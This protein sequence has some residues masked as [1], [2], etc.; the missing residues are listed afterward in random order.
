MIIIHRV[1]KKRLYFSPYN[2][3]KRKL[4]FTVFGTHYADD[5]LYQ[6]HLKLIFKICLS[7]N[8]ANVI[9]TSSKMP[10]S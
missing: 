10:F 4:T 1:R 6:E 7:I 3:I 2:F 8:I 5:T 9:M